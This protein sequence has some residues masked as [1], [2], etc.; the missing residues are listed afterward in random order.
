MKNGPIMKLNPAAIL[1][2]DYLEIMSL[3]S[4]LRTFSPATFE[5]NP[6]RYYRLKRIQA[7]LKAL[8]IQVQTVQDF[9]IGDWC[10]FRTKKFS[11]ATMLYFMTTCVIT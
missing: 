8:D 3:C 4:G 6:P 1:L 7:C 10:C 2:Q 11:T 9:K 5:H